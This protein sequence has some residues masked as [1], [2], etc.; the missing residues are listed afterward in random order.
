MFWDELAAQV[1]ALYARLDHEV[2]AFAAASGLSCPQG[3]GICC[4]PDKV[5]ATVVEMVPLALE[6]LRTGEAEH[7][8][9]ELLSAG[10]NRRCILYRQEWTL[11]GRWGCSRYPH[12]PVVCR[13]FGFAG[14]LDRH[15]IPR[16][17]HCR[18]MKAAGIGGGGLVLDHPQFPMVRF[19]AAG[20]AARAIY[21]DLG[22]EALP[23]NEALLRAL[24]R[25]ELSCRLME[26]ADE[27][28][29]RV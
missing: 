23:I 9:E 21:P 8:V 10:A 15:G 11:Q 18:G 22:R 2:A 19:A 17:A 6:V 24:E 12:R 25:V 1:T 3:C 5:E 4:L 14:N 29:G 16:L 20:M 27:G 28:E 7:A 13:L 26:K